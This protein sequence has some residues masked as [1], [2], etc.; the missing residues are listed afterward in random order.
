MIRPHFFIPSQYPVIL[1]GPQINNIDNSFLSHNDSFNRN[2]SLSEDPIPN[3]R[4]SKFTRPQTFS[5]LSK[6]QDS[7]SNRDTVN[8]TQYSQ[9]RSFYIDKTRRSSSTMDINSFLTNKSK[10]NNK[11]NTILF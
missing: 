9:N 10:N 11:E 2:S 4:S 8:L 1:R 6:V 7:N 5:I 3:P